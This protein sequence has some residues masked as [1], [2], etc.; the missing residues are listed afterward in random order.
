MKIKTFF[1]KV[2]CSI[3]SE[4]DQM[5]ENETEEETEPIK[6]HPRR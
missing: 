5:V 3:Q 4:N 1:R 6:T 2:L